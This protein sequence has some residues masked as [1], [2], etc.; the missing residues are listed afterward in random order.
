[1]AKSIVS[2]ATTLVMSGWLGAQPVVDLP[3][4]DAVSVKAVPPPTSRPESKVDPE[5]IDYKSVNLTSLVMMAYGMGRDDV[6]G[7]DWMDSQFYEVTATMPPSTPR[8][9]R[10]IMMQA[11]LTDRWRMSAHREKQVRAAYAVT[12]AKSGLKMHELN[13]PGPDPHYPI[14]EHFTRDVATVSGKMSVMSLLNMVGSGLIYPMHDMT[15]LT[16]DYKVGLEWMRG[17]LSRGDASPGTLFGEMEKQLGLKV[18]AR[19][20]P[21]DVLVID[22]IDKVPVGN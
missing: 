14:K 15:G 12:I 21:L 13:P 9:R 18:E 11:L 4:F 20:V 17:D 16:A 22:H 19:K 5:R 6:K 8:E 3:R 2:A 1:M 7:P 10:L